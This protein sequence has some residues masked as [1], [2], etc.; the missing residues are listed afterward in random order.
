MMPAHSITEGI[1]IRNQAQLTTRL[2]P[3]PSNP[4]LTGNLS[5]RTKSF[6]GNKIPWGNRESIL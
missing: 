6:K 4:L 2:A 3:V 1:S 5:D